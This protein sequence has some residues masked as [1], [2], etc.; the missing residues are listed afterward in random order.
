M[1]NKNVAAILGLFLGPFGVHRFYLGQIGLGIFYCILAITGI[2]AILGVIDFI[3]FLSMDEEVF[4]AKYNR[5]VRNRGYDTDFDR[6]QNRNRRTKEKR[7]YQEKRK[8]YERPKSR[9]E[10]E[11]RPVRRSRPT[12]SRKKSNPF[13]KSG[14]E[15]YREFEFEAAIADFKKA[16]QIDSNDIAVH[17]NMSC[18]YSL[19]E[20][21]DNAFFHL[22]KAVELGFVDFERIKTHDALAYLRIQDEFDEFARKGYRLTAA[23]DPT[24][25][26]QSKEEE[27]ANT[28]DLLEQLKKLGALREKGLLTEQEFQVQKKK[29]LG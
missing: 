19:T 11:R 25:M 8:T 1:K 28:S 13:K 5:N 4:D 17:F 6:P 7:T 20:E 15:K 23:L 9:Y 24:T 21:A 16:L 2:S 22:S 14:L 18:A 3:A 26:P 10:E 27:L 12:A 29:L